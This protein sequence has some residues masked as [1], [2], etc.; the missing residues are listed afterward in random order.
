MAQII[1]GKFSEE[2]LH[3]LLME[4]S[5]TSDTGARIASLSKQFLDIPYTEGTLHGDS[6]TP[7]EFVINLEGVDCFT[8]LDYVEAMRLSKSFSEF[9]GNLRAIRYRS[10]E[11]AFEKRNHFFTDWI[12]YNSDVVI[13]VT[14]RVAGAKRKKAMKKLNENDDGTHMIAGV[15]CVER[16]IMYVPSGA[17]DDE[18]IAELRTGDYLGIYSQKP[19][20][21]VSHVGIFINDIN[22]VFLR[23]A[24][25]T[26]QK[27]VDEDFQEYLSDKPGIVVLRAK[28]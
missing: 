4:S 27:V 17:V 14:E 22:C 10:G 2:M 15:A 21:D 8:L 11:V 19:G 1:L 16:E 5:Q 7:E 6:V 13:D 25:H 3:D 28:A 26:Q 24:S 18:I 20:L 9:R 12:E 23:H